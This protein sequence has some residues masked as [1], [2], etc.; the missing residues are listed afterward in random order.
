MPPVEN[1]YDR[2]IAIL[3]EHTE[4]ELGCSV[5]AAQQK[6]C[7][8]GEEVAPIL[9]NMSTRQYRLRQRE[10]REQRRTSPIVK[11]VASDKPRANARKQVSRRSASAR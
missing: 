5:P 9:N 4:E 1:R 3:R 10:L 7:N 6:T 8:Y 11:E 2:L